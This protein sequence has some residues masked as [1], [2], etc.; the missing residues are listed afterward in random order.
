MLRPDRE[1]DRA[2]FY[3]PRMPIDAGAYAVELHI[4]SS[5]PPMTSLGHLEVFVGLDQVASGE[6]LSGQPATLVFDA[7]QNLPLELRFVYSREAQVCLHRAVI[8]N[9]SAT[10]ADR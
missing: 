3:G 10:S 9:R 8:S 1:P 2:V 6:V 4:S 5:A 7:K